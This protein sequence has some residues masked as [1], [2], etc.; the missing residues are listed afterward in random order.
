LSATNAIVVPKIA[1]IPG[2]P[3]V[4]FCAAPRPGIIEKTSAAHAAQTLPNL[5]KL[6]GTMTA[7][8]VLG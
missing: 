1:G 7:P 3:K 4:I 2:T 6:L 8:P 5:V